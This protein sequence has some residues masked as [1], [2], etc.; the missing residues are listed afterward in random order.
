MTLWLG[1][2]FAGAVAQQAR[3]QEAVSP[4]VEEDRTSIYR[5]DPFLNELAEASA[6]E[7][8]PGYLYNHFN[9]KLGRR[10]WSLA[11]RDGSFVYAMGPGSVQPAWRLDLRATPEQARAALFERAPELAKMLETRGGVAYVRLTP[12]GG[13]SLVPHQTIA[14]IFDEETGRRWEWHGIRR[15]AVVHTYGYEWTNRNGS[16]SPVEIYG[17]IPRVPCW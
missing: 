9:P 5:F 13:W 10:V 6:A 14:S 2:L 3:S 1:W 16:Y 15:V 7:V 4:P 8:K 11:S 12:E 17:M